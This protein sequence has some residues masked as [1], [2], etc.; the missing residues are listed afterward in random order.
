MGAGL[1]WEREAAGW[2]NHKA[3]RFVDAGGLRWH[4]QVYGEG[5][6]ALLLHGSAASVHSWR[7]FGPRLAR[8]Y[9]VVAP[10]LPGH[11]FSAPPPRRLQTLGGAGQ[12]IAELLHALELCPRV[13]IGHS[14]GAAL[15]AR[16]ALDA[17]I[18][19]D[20]LISINGAFLP[21]SGIAGHLFPTTARLLTY[22]PLV[23]FWL[24]FRARNRDFL[25]DVL[26]RTGSRIDEAGIDLYQRL[27]THPGHVAAALGMMARTHDGLYAL[28]EDLPRLTVPLVLFAASGDR[29]VPPAQAERVR[30]RV[31]SA[32]LE[33]LSD[34]GHL[35]HE[36]APDRVAEQ[37]LAA[38]RTTAPKGR[39]EADV[40]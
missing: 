37:V 32:R 23:P 12:G 24:A 10:D 13:A 9:T 39:G 6:P 31:P 27:A 21:F 33:T 1:A 2:P 11:G 30:L 18:R 34:L 25:A 8:H 29:T 17:R 7:D 19:P 36:E 14:V 26:A 5:P 20:V 38:I 40:R 16:M 22:N 15:L 35:A 4:V 28:M 3:S